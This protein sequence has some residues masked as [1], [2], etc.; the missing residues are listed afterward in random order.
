M[1]TQRRRSGDE[2]YVRLKEW[3]KGQK[4]SE[5][6]AGHILRAD[7]YQSINPSHPL[8]GK[9]DSKDIVCSK[10]S[11]TWVAG[12]YFPRE[13]QKFSVIKKKFESDLQGSI[14]HNAPGFIFIT[15]QKLTVLER[16]KLVALNSRGATE[17]YHLERLVHLLNSPICY[18]VRLEFLEI[19]LTRAEQLSYFTER[20]K[21]MHT[22][23]ATVEELNKLI[24]SFSK[25][26]EIPVSELQNFKSTLDGIIGN[27]NFAT[28]FGSAPIDKLR[29]PIKELTEFKNLLDDLVGGDYFIGGVSPINKLQIPISQLKEFKSLLESIVGFADYFSHTG[30]GLIPFGSIAPISKLHVP[31]ENL[32][33]YERTLDNIIEK[34]RLLNNFTDNK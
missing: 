32:K 9:D 12:C 26:K 24:K 18:G 27:N 10:N 2:T 25:Q 11:L 30:T 22:L 29:V 1:T 31:L 15:N 14:K 17:I 7:G 28:F 20:D 34:Q 5:R 3:L 16:E 4:E 33:E 13:Q 6:L 8:G 23:N 19:E 21:N